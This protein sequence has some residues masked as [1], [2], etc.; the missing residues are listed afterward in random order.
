M[1]LDPDAAADLGLSGFVAGL[2]RSHLLEFV[3]QLTMQLPAKIEKISPEVIRRHYLPCMAVAVKMMAADNEMFRQMAMGRDMLVDQYLS[4]DIADEY[5]GGMLYNFCTL[6]YDMASYMSC[7]DASEKLGFRNYAYN[8]LHYIEYTLY[9]DDEYM[10]N[11]DPLPDGLYER[12][13]AKFGSYYS[14]DYNARPEFLICAAVESAYN[15]GQYE[16]I[17]DNARDIITMNLYILPN[18]T[19]GYI[20]GLLGMASRAVGRE[21][22]AV[23]IAKEELVKRYG[24]SDMFDSLVASAIVRRFDSQIFTDFEAYRD[25]LKRQGYRFADYLPWYGSGES[26]D[27]SNYD[28]Y[29]QY[30]KEGAKLLGGVW[31]EIAGSMYRSPDNISKLKPVL[32]YFDCETEE[33]FVMLSLFVANQIFHDGD[34]ALALEIIDRALAYYDTIYKTLVPYEIMDIAGIYYQ[35]GNAGKVDEILCKY[36]LP[37]MDVCEYHDEFLFSDLSCTASCAA[38]LAEYYKDQPE[39][40][41]GLADKAISMID[42]LQSDDDKAD[43]LGLLCGCYYSMDDYDKALEV[44]NRTLQYDIAE[45]QRAWIE[46]GGAEIYYRTH[47][48][49]RAVKAYKRYAKEYLWLL[50]APFYCEIMSCAAHVGDRACMADCGDRYVESIG[51]EIDDKLYNLSSEERERFWSSIADQNMFAEICDAVRDDKEQKAILASC[52]YDYSLLMKGLLLNAD[53]RIDRMLTEHP[54]SVVRE[55]YAQMK[56]LS[57]RIDNMTLRGGDPTQMTF[58]REALTAAQRDITMVVRSMGIDSDTAGSVAWRDVQSRL[59]ENDVAIEFMRLTGGSDNEVEPV[60]VAVV[61]RRDWSS[62]RMV[63]LCRESKLR[64]YVDGDSARNRQLYN[65][66]E[67]TELWPLIWQPLQDFV[68][69]GEN[70]YFSVDGLLNVVNIEAIMPDS[71][72]DR[73]AD[74]RY[75]LHRL[76]STRELCGERSDRTLEHAVIYGGLN[77]DMGAEAMAEQTRTYAD[78][79]LAVSRGSVACGTLPETYLKETYDEALDIAAMLQTKDISTDLFTGEKGIEESFKAL[80]GKRFELLHLG[81]HGFYMTCETEYQAGDELLSPM[82]RS[83]LMLSRKKTV[84]ADDREDGLLLAREI[85]DMDLSSVDLVVLSACQTAQGDITGDGVFG[86]QRGFKQAGVGSIVMSLWEVD[87]EM[88][89][90]MMTAFYRNLADGMERHEAFR[91]ARAATKAEYPDK[92]WA[93]F[94]MLD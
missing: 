12:L 61:L 89:Q 51:A 9:G 6:A 92:D 31:K 19:E 25:K 59:G 81:T 74:E 66:F 84:E 15:V 13:W 49:S 39:F 38:L 8:N 56:D 10:R 20:S 34:T 18:H 88:T 26:I 60:Y 70:V 94:I 78:V 90:Y 62:P 86:L 24:K 41:I 36:M 67:I 68:A 58:L 85:A 50:T 33:R 57:A 42:R 35:L 2:D 77:Y 1:S 28:V 76:S 37:Y 7:A 54:D 27:E 4:G 69:E 17:T 11:I 93:A 44:M 23:A 30:F 48:W 43:I 22:E 64:K 32:D 45:D 3:G 40:A 53:N 14:G 46:L 73:M 29:A 16:L 75:V 82:M 72:D 21:S 91:A 65:T 71:D 80:S 63:E 47:E 55:R 79:D 52:A 83:G 87:S 5:V